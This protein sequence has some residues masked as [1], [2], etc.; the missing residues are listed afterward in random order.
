MVGKFLTAW[1]SGQSSLSAMTTGAPIMADPTTEM[2]YWTYQIISS[3][4]PASLTSGHIGL[5]YWFVQ[6]DVVGRSYSQLNELVQAIVGTQETQG[7]AGLTGTFGGV[8][9]KGVTFQNRRD[10]QDEPAQNETHGPY[11]I[12]LDFKIC[13]EEVA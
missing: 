11:R 6:I 4:I 1:M 5:H 13:T 10:F 7:L 2:P 9:V 8:V 12:Q 3:D